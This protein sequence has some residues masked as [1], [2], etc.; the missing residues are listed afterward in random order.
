MYD[1]CMSRGCQRIRKNPRDA[2]NLS[3]VLLNIND[4]GALIEIMIYIYFDRF[5]TPAV[6]RDVFF[7]NVLLTQGAL[8]ERWKLGS[9]PSSVLWR[10]RRAQCPF[11]HTAPHHPSTKVGTLALDFA[12]CARRQTKHAYALKNSEI[13]K[14]RHCVCV[15]I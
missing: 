14:L 7:A 5:R 6:H 8:C 11:V 2:M 10:Q 13:E 9:A 4:T 1:P 15:T 12:W 3:S